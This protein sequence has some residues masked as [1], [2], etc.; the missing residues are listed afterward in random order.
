MGVRIS[1]SILC[2]PLNRESCRFLLSVIAAADCLA[3]FSHFYR[4]GSCCLVL[5]HTTSQWMMG[6]LNDGAN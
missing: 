3:E 1:G 2:I 5:A 6:G 4:G